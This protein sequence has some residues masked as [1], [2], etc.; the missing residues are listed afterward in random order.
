MAY[1]KSIH[2]DVITS[3]MGPIEDDDSAKL[4]LDHS[5][6]EPWR[7][8]GDIYVTITDA[9][10]KNRKLNHLGGFDPGN[11]VELTLWILTHWG[12]V[13][14][15]CVSKHCFFNFIYWQLLMIG[16][17]QWSPWLL[18]ICITLLT[19]FYGLY[20]SSMKLR[21]CQY[22]QKQ[23]YP[24]T[25]LVLPLISGTLTNREP[26]D[27]VCQHDIWGWGGLGLH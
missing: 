27:V 23:H 16:E 22:T 9:S 24:L 21:F 13:T 14:H 19:L 25:Y 17:T 26:F 5:G 3:S 1:M 4:Q 11:G 18:N 6:I 2:H 12:R 10:S 7:M 20:A 15:I 8:E